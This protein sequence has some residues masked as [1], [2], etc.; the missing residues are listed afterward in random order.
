MSCVYKRIIFEQKH[1]AVGDRVCI[2]SLINK[3]IVF[4]QPGLEANRHPRVA[5]PYTHNIKKT[6]RLRW[7]LFY[8]A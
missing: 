5:S 8:N 4:K 6:R 7:S 3:T 1:T 2:K